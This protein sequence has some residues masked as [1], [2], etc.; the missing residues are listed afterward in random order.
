[1]STILDNIYSDVNRTSLM[2]LL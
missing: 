2:V 1:M